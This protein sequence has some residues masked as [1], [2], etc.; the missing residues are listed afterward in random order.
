PYDSTVVLTQEDKE[1]LAE[2]DPELV[3][4]VI[5]NGIDLSIFEPK[6]IE[7]DLATLL[8]VGNYEYPPNHDAAL[9]LAQD[10]FPKVLA[11]IPQAKLQLV[12]NAPSDD[13]LQLAS[14]KIEVTGRVP[15]VQDY[16]ASATIFVC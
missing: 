3:I 1:E 6:L 14:D 8:F 9:V 7:R 11:S 4:E 13:M 12:G 5:P 15:S 10:I 16:L 2:I